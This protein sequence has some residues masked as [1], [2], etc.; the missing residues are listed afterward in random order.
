MQKA[1]SV[2]GWLVGYALSAVS[3]LAFFLLGHHDPALPA[4]T[5]FIALTA[6]YGTAFALLAGYVGA[7]ISRFSPRGTA[8]AIALTIVLVA[9]WSWWETPRHSHWSHLVALCLMA[10]AA[11]LGGLLPSRHSARVA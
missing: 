7:H 10:P 6:L 5:A 8:L 9:S 11:F 3:T 1:R 4:S 2:L